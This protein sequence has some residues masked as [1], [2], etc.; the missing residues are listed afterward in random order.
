MT[1][2][3]QHNAAFRSGADVSAIPRYP[4]LRFRSSLLARTLFVVGAMSVTAMVAFILFYLFASEE[5]ANTQTS[6]KLYELIEAARPAAGE[7]C[8]A[9]DR[10]LGQ[11]TARAIVKSGDVSKVVIQCGERQLAVAEREPAEASASSD[12]PVVRALFSPFYTYE[13][14]GEISLTPN[15]RAIEGR[16]A[17][18]VGNVGF[19]LALFAGGILVAIGFATHAVV[20]RPIKIIS[21]TLHFVNAGRATPQAVPLL[22][23][24]NVVGRLAGEVNDLL[25]HFRNLLE[26]KHETLPQGARDELLQLAAPILPQGRDGTVTDNQ[27]C[28]DGVL[29]DSCLQAPIRSEAPTATAVKGAVLLVGASAAATDMQKLADELAMRGYQ[30]DV[31]AP[32]ADLL[33]GSGFDS[34]QFVVLDL[35]AAE[36]L[37]ARLSTETPPW[38]LL[39]P[40][41]C[42]RGAIRA[43]DEFAAIAFL[44]M[45]VNPDVLVTILARFRPDASVA[46]IQG[47]GRTGLR[48]GEEAVVWRLDM[49]A[50]RLAGP[51]GGVA[52]LTHAE[53]AFLAALA[54]FPGQA[55]SR[56]DLITAM[57]HRSEYYDRR[58]MDTFVS[59]LRKKVITACGAEL[60]LRSIHA[61]G[62]AL[63][64]PILPE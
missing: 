13:Q 40:A 43:L 59:R 57:G 58:R 19:M 44:E 22:H 10:T 63:A 56:G 49:T 1:S 50:W 52:A 36:R 41:G 20:L 27:L 28:G 42:A 48:A 21:K 60:P 37:S 23:G 46:L 53:T 3:F 4:W 32:D 16:V 2:D 26:R 8:F 31:C 64:A 61:F 5:R 14:I 29:A 35:E 6:Q 11:E 38:I 18:D 54:K 39:V 25:Q 17:S 30:A 33:A 45:P 51:G 34:W 24:D 12:I 55:V 7:A 47:G 9:G 15:G 62:Y